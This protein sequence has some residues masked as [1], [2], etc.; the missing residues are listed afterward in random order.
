MR[1]GPFLAA[2]LSALALLRD[3]I[4]G[5]AD[6]S[7]LLR[8]GAHLAR[9]CTAC[10][11]LDGT[12]N[13]IPSIL[14]WDAERFAAT[15]RFYQTGERTNPVMVSIARSLDEEQV[16]ALAAYY[17]SLPKPAPKAKK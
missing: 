15:L 16:K 1:S 8:Y 7:R 14:G 4:A 13:G 5:A 3:P 6:D 9:E 12:E 11:R 2:A 17:A 10:H